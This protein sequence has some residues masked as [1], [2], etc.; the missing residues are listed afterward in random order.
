MQLPEGFRLLHGAFFK[1]VCCLHRPLER[2]VASQ[3]PILWAHGSCIRPMWGRRRWRALIGTNS[4]RAR[5]G[6][7]QRSGFVTAHI[8]LTELRKIFSPAP[9]LAT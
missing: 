5:S 1:M 2:A 7:V 3:H 6:V 8:R 9:I 4:L